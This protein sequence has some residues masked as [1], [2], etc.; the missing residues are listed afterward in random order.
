MV[1]NVRYTRSVCANT[2]SAVTGSTRREFLRRRSRVGVHAAVDAPR[3][4]LPRAVG[5]W[6]TEH[7]LSRALDPGSPSSRPDDRR[8]G[9]P[10]RSTLPPAHVPGR[11]AQQRVAVGAGPAPPELRSTAAAEAASTWG[12]PH[13]SHAALTGSPT[14]GGR[15]GG[16]AGS[17]LLS[18]G[19]E[20]QTV[21]GR[22]RGWTGT[23]SRARLG[24]CPHHTGRGGI[25]AFFLGL[26]LFVVVVGFADAKLGWPR[27]GDDRH[28][29]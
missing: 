27:P 12:T 5:S 3:P 11:T 13:S 21:A 25:V 2:S 26:V 1:R 16:L 9:T 4:A 19:S 24:G 20:S 8:R 6:A 17:Q 15:G 14:R 18:G 10:S 22:R 23:S 7:P 29:R 28:R